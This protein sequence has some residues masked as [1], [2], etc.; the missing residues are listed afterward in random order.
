MG[1]I[2]KINNGERMQI[3]FPSDLNMLEKI[4]SEAVSFIKSHNLQI[5]IFAFRLALHEGLSNAVKH[6]NKLVKELKTKLAISLEGGVMK[7]R[8]E[9][10]GDGFNWK[11]LP[12]S[13]GD[14][15]RPSGRGIH[16]LKAYGYVPDYNEKGNVVTLTKEL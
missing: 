7:I 8:I 11:G 10:S 14:F 12:E 13:T 2:E 5:D 4:V 6:G 15:S 9:D 1:E 16:L 3:V